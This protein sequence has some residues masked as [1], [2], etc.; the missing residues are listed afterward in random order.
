[1]NQWF[2]NKAVYEKSPQ[3]KAKVEYI[4]KRDCYHCV[5]CGA[6]GE[7]VHHISYKNT[8][9]NGSLQ[10]IVTNET[11]KQL[12]LLC[13]ACHAEETALCRS[14]LDANTLIKQAL[15]YIES[16][17]TA[18]SVDCYSQ[19]YFCDYESSHKA[20]KALLYRAI[21]KRVDAD[22]ILLLAML[23]LAYKSTKKPC[24][25]INPRIEED[26]FPAEICNLPNNVERY[27]RDKLGWGKEIPF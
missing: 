6:K 10:D 5:V 7:C 26:R 24:L 16:R 8:Q 17:C 9:L 1:M 11:P 27:E 12:V 3:W 25:D 21:E 18:S 20:M 23:K 19:S 15:S 14:K 13:S 2:D 4:K 22:E